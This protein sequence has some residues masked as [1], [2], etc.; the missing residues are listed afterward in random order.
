MQLLPLSILEH[1][2]YPP[3]KLPH[4]LAISYTSLLIVLV[5]TDLL[6]VSVDLLS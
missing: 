3:K 6:S 2:Y 4:P 1:F 5:T